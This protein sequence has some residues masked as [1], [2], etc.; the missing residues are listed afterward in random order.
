M[1]EINVNALLRNVAKECDELIAKHKFKI[2]IF[3]F[4]KFPEAKQC[5][6]EHE[7]ND[8]LYAMFSSIADAYDIPD[9][10][11]YADFLDAKYPEHEPMLENV[12]YN[13]AVCLANYDIKREYKT[14]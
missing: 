9:A 4:S 3:Y 13:F 5:F 7:E 6:V 12:Y 11:V 8:S 10:L 14:K 1:N 2:N